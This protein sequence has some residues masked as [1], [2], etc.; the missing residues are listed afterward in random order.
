MKLIII[1]TMILVVVLFIIRTIIALVYIHSNSQESEDD[2]TLQETQVDNQST[3][4]NE[5]L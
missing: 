4:E 1:I 3:K 5:I 2:P